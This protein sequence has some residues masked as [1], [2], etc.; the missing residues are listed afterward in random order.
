MEIPEKRMPLEASGF[1]VPRHLNLR[2]P[3]D[4][5]FGVFRFRVPMDGNI[6]GRHSSIASGNPRSPFACCKRRPTVNNIYVCAIGMDSETTNFQWS[7]FHL[8][9]ASS[10][11]P[12]ADRTTHTLGSIVN[13]DFQTLFADDIAFGNWQRDMP[14]KKLDRLKLAARI[15]AESRTHL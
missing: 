12:V 8:D 1:D 6:E 4:W 13:G 11:C 5:Q 2:D 14:E 3:A 15:M 7:T 10:L 9:E